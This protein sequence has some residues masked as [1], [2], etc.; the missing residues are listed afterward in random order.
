MILTREERTVESL[1]GHDAPNKSTL[2]GLSGRFQTEPT[3]TH[4]ILEK[5][6][7]ASRYTPC[8]LLFSRP[9]SL[10]FLIRKSRQFCAWCNVFPAVFNS[11]QGSK[12]THDTTP[13][14]LF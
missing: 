6:A 14:E 7:R 2:L 8:I 1:G 13:F 5:R 12:K 4:F 10:I 11:T 9:L 3:P